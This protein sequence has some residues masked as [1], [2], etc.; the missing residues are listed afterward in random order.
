MQEAL[1]AQSLLIAVDIG[2]ALSNSLITFELT[3][4]LRLRH[5][6]GLFNAPIGAI[7]TLGTHNFAPLKLDDAASS[8]LGGPIGELD[9][10]FI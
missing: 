6:P 9:G 8:I 4:D 1:H 3:D 2:H 5:L 7:L 10:N